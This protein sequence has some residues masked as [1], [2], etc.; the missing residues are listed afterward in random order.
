ML[1]LKE[2]R[3]IRSQRDH[4]FEIIKNLMPKA[5]SA[6]TLARLHSVGRVMG[7]TKVARG[8]RPVVFV[9]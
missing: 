2:I 6:G 4:T 8:Y 9:A 3:D 7:L 5:C 1:G